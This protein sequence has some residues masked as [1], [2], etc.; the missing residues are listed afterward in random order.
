ML[1]F[2]DAVPPVDLPPVAD[3]AV[4]DDG[5]PITGEVMNLLARRNLLFQ[6]VQTPSTQF[7]ITIAV[8]SGRVSARPTPPIRARS[9]RRSAVNSP[10]SVARCGSTAARS[11][12]AGSPAMPPGSDCSSST[13]AAA[14]SKGCASVCAAPIV[15]APR[16]SPAPAASRFADHVV[17]DGATEFSL[18]RLTTYAVIDLGSGALTPRRV[19]LTTLISRRRRSDR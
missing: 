4:V 3:L 18:P 12:S 17:A 8:G 13:T 11:S 5:S 19:P 15:P 14:T 1:T 16:A 2:L 7:P 9:R 6:V 10:T